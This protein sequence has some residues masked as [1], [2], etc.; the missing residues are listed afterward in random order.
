MRHCLRFTSSVFLSLVLLCLASVAAFAQDL[1]NVTITGRV[2]DQNGAVI[3][4]ASVTATLVKNK[5]ERTGTADADGRYRIIQRE[6]GIYSVKS[7]FTR[8]TAEKQH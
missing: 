6:P 2:M 7:A 1:D 4:R 3:P 5:V 8:F